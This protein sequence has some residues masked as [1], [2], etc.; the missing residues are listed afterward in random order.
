MRRYK[1][2]KQEISVQ[3]QSLKCRAFYN[4]FVKFHLFLNGIKII[5]R[6]AFTMKN[7][8]LFF[9]LITAVSV[10]SAA[11]MPSFAAEAS[12]F[13]VEIEH[14]YGTTSIEAQ[15][16]RIVTLFDSNSDSVL[17]LGI[18]PVGVSAVGYGNVEENGLLPWTNDAFEKLGITPNVFQDTDGTDYEAVNATD[19]DLILIPNSGV[20]EEDYN[21]LSEIAPTVPF[22]KT[23]YAT[24]W[25]EEMTITAKALGME[26]EGAQLIADTKDLIADK[27]SE[28]P[29]LE[30]KTAAFCYIDPSNLSMVYIYMPLDPRAAFLEELGMKVPEAITSMAGAEDFSVDLSAENIDLLNDVDVIVCYGDDSLIGQLQADEL[31]NTV[32]AVKNGAIAVISSDSDLY[33]GTYATVLSIPAVIDEYLDLLGAAAQNVQ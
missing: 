13:P 4:C 20:T 24:T 1:I 33:M 10:F 8:K 12:S 23:A 31:M 27:L 17:A 32:P 16:E 22:A 15:P 2:F 19:P 11:A 18:A 21:R 28:H 30:G 7:K 25:E 9:S 5:L 26:E 14:A 6:G 29:E 3:S